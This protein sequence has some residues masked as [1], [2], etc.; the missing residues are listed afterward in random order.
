M[1]TDLMKYE[2]NYHKDPTNSNSIDDKLIWLWLQILMMY[3]IG[4]KHKTM[5]KGTKNE[6]LKWLGI[7]LGVVRISSDSIKHTNY[8]TLM[9]QDLKMNMTIPITYYYNFSNNSKN[10]VSWNIY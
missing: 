7:R 9:N 8:H 1:I 4:S 6:L 3:I 5:I 2:I 10:I